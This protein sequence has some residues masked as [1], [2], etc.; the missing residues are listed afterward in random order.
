MSDPV[1]TGRNVDELCNDAA[2]HV[3]KIVLELMNGFADGVDLQSGRALNE[4]VAWASESPATR[5]LTSDRK[6]QAIFGAFGLLVSEIYLALATERV[7][8]AIAT[9]TIT[10]GS[11]FLLS[12]LARDIALAH[13][14]EMRHEGRDSLPWLSQPL[15]GD[16]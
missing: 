10:S 4:A 7:Q 2:E 11:D 15:E 6:L 8:L 9:R 12:K 3:R 16:E 5:S 13:I 14:E 1:E